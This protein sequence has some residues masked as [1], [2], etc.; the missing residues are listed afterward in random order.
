MSEERSLTLEVRYLRVVRPEGHFVPLK[1]HLIILSA[2]VL[3]DV[4]DS[5][6]M[7]DISNVCPRGTAAGAFLF[8]QNDIWIF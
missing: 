8:T 1:W 4:D 5:G 6:Q 2:H 3:H 7:S